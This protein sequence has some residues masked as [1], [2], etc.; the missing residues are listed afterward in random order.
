MTSYTVVFYCPDRHIQYDGRMPY[1][2][3]VGGG[4]TSRVRMARALQRAGHIVK[5][6]V[7]CERRQI[8]DGVEYLPLDEVNKIQADVLILNTSGDSLDLTP[9]LAI[10]VDT[11]LTIVWISGTAAPKGLDR[12]KWDFI[13]AKSN[14]LQ[15]VAHEEWSIPEARIFVCYNGF[16]QEPYLQAER[17]RHHRDPHRLVYFS[18]PSKGLD[19]AKAILWQIRAKDPRFRLAIYGGNQLWGQP[20]APIASEDGIEYL[21]MIGQE[22]LAKELI[23]CSYSLSL[24][25]RR[26]PF[27]MVIT[28]AMR[29]GC[30]VLASPVGAYPELIRD[31]EDGFLIEGD[32][33]AE[34][35][36]SCAAELILALAENPQMRAYVRRNAREVIWDTDSMASVWKGHWDWL[37]GGD[38]RTVIVHGFDRLDHCPWCGAERLWLADGYH[39]TQCGRYSRFRY[40]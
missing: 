8:I 26:E 31:G 23:A 35:T 3:G 24:Q 30:I 12:V 11:R 33:E 14:F 5:M 16:D 25:S 32:H 28:E 6:A 19:T 20:E 38:S 17:Q 27:G 18:H 10:E 29:A 36:R 22:R 9:V 7:N 40:A 21:G 1:R 39:C 2:I 4:I 37:F 13:Y 15:K 34:D